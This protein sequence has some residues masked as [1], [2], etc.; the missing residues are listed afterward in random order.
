MQSLKVKKFF[1]DY[2]IGSVLIVVLFIVLIG[3]FTIMDTKGFLTLGKACPSSGTSQDILDSAQLVLRNDEQC[4][5]VRPCE[6]LLRLRC[7][8]TAKVLDIPKQLFAMDLLIM[9][10][11]NQLMDQYVFAGY[12]DKSTF[13]VP[14]GL[15][16]FFLFYLA[17]LV[18]AGAVLFALW[19]QKLLRQTFSLPS[20]SRTSQLLNPLLFGIFLA[21]LMLA[22]NFQVDRMFE[23]PNVE[24]VQVSLAFFQTV[25]GI[26][27]AILVAPL[28]EEMIF[29]GVLLRFFIDRKR[30]LL[31][32]ALT[33]VFFAL[34]H[35]LP[36]EELGWQIYR[37]AGY[38]MVSAVLCWV[39]IRQ[40]NLWSP[41]VFH[42]GYNATMI[43]FL[44]L[45]A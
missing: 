24:R 21:L 8:G 33:S 40:K 44:N 36:E 15:V 16:M 4:E 5:F 1:L 7:E 43:G 28:V 10:V 41:I 25:T 27:A 45:F 26:I 11:K 3:N 29:R 12:S 32:V 31:G 14:I 42:S 23:Y 19:R 13:R 34:L 2:L 18:E 22:V 30:Q 39:Y 37:F 20:G 17:V 35:S 9:R 6:E 38:F